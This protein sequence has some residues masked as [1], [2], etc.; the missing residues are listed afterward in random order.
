MTATTATTTLAPANDTTSPVAAQRRSAASPIP[1][2]RL[3][4]VELRKMFNT[5]SGMWLMCS[6]G[7]LALLATGAVMIFSADADLTYDNFGAAVGIPM[8]II[9]PI[10]ATLSVTS[11]WSQRSGLTTFTLVPHRGRVIGAKLAVAVL[12]GVAAMVLAL[13]VGALGNLVG[14]SV[15]GID[16]VWNLSVSHMLTI[17]LATVLNM[18]IGFMLGVLIRNSP[19]AIVGYFV[20]NFVL[21]PLTMLLATSQSW[22]RDLQPWMDF[23]FT[24][25]F[26]FNGDLTTRQWSQLGVTGLFW[27][28]IPLAIGL[29][30]VRRSEV[31]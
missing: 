24:Q 15:A 8:V 23:N 20:Y 21:P 1:T 12:V 9:L 3:L 7:I 22:W 25:G 28:A 6:I 31:K 5:R 13:S 16:P 26:L 27:L 10:I 18:L 30:L 14:A 17:T 29:F 2:S 11:E 4:K 19:G